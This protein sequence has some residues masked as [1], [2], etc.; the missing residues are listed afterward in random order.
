M[1]YLE[2][3]FYQIWAGLQILWIPNAREHNGW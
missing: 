3:R 1:K 2:I